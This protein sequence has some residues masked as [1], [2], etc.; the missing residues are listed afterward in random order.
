MD[1]KMK[2]SGVR[3]SLDFNFLPEMFY[4]TPAE[5]FNALEQGKEEFIS[6]I[7]NEFYKGVNEKLFKDNPIVFKP[8][9]F[10][11]TKYLLAKSKFLYYIELP[12]QEDAMV[13]AEAY[14]LGFDLKIAYESE[15]KFFT[16]EKTQNGPYMLCGVALDNTHIN[17]GQVLESA[18]NTDENADK[19]L[20]IMFHD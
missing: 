15:L 9:D 8:E 12:K 1:D 6:N 14:G 3:Y 2:L 18:T 20:K 10:K 19:M 5:F 17:Y 13:W 4:E 16:V 11:I 7:F